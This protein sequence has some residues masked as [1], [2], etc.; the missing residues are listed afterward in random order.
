MAANTGGDVPTHFGA[1]DATEPLEAFGSAG[2]YDRAAL[3]RLYRATRPRVARG[4]RRQGD[5]FESITLVSP[6]PDA[7]LTRLNP[8]TLIIR[9]TIISASQ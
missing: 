2:R 8:G 6:Y 1:L 3:A 4:W 5:R 7:T 9:F